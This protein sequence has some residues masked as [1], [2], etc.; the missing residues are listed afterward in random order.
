MT[1]ALIT[2]IVFAAFVLTVIPGMLAWA[3]RASRDDGAEYARAARRRP[4]PRPHYPSP[5]VGTPTG[6]RRPLSDA[7]AR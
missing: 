2:N 3:I 5:R 4:M 7:G 1:L 6:P